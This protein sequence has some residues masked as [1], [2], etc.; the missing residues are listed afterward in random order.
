MPRVH[1][2]SRAE[3]GFLFRSQL[4]A[5]LLSDRL[6]HFALQVENPVQWPLVGFAPE[7]A[8]VGAVEQLHRDTH[9]V[10]FANDGSFEDAIHSKFM[11]NLGQVLLRAFVL[12]HRGVGD[13]AQ[14]LNAGKLR[15]QFFGHAI[16][17]KVLG[18]VAGE[19]LQRE[20]GDGAY[21]AAR[22]F[23]IE[24]M[25]S[26]PRDKS[27]GTTGKE[28]NPEPEL[29]PARRGDGHCRL[30]PFVVALL[31]NQCGRRDA[32]SACCAGAELAWGGRGDASRT[33]AMNLY[34][35][36]GSVST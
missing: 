4:N 10:V 31:R 27:D 21:G 5:N 19:V 8:V 20:Y 1:R 13:D 6:G 12:H 23:A 15:D 30:I 18:R 29:L 22:A 32:G 2:A 25:P 28:C 33:G 7:M 34:P 36:P 16:C 3:P 26:D 14:R 11:R 17:E 24:V 35:L 9:L